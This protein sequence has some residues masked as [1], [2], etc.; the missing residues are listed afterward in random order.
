MEK[1]R[2]ASKNFTEMRRQAEEHLKRGVRN[3]L[4]FSASHGEMQ[5][6]VHELA[7]HQI[8]LEMQQEE[9]LQSREELEEALERFTELYDFAP[10]GYLTLARD[11]TILQVNLTGTKLLGVERSLLLGERFERF[12]TLEDLSAFNALLERAFTSD[13]HVSCEV[14]LRNNEVSPLLTD[15]S[16]FPKR[17]ALPDRMVRIDAV[18]SNDG[19][20]CRTT[21]SDTMQRS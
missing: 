15:N 13:G 10:L 19:Q 18:V 8:E 2:I 1:S 3:V 6:L 11:G 20:E 12:V 17:C 14:K 9:L 16:L 21:V 7:I 5:R 4:K